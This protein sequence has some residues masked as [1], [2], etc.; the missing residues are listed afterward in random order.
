MND[1][2]R[3]KLRRSSVKRS[4]KSK[5]EESNIY[6][7]EDEE[8]VQPKKVKKPKKEK[9]KP[10]KETTAEY[11][12][13]ETSAPSRR[14][15]FKV[16]KG[17]KGSKFK[18]FLRILTALVIIAVIVFSFSYFL[19]GGI[20]E[21]VSGFFATLGSGE[22]PIEYD[23]SLIA[24]SQ[25]IGSCNYLLNDTSLC[26]YTGGGKELFKYQ[27]GFTNPV[28]SVSQTRAVLFNEG[29]D[30]A[31]IFNKSG[32]MKTIKPGSKIINATVGRNGAFAISCVGGEY[33]ST[34]YVYSKK[35]KKVYTW[36]SAKD[37]VNSLCLSPN[38]KKLAV[39]TLNV[40]NAEATDKL[41]VLEYNS[42]DP[43]FTKDFK[44]EIILSMRST[45]FGFSTVSERGYKYF[46]WRNY[47]AK[48]LAVKN[49]NLSLLRTNGGETLLVFNR[50]NDKTDNRIV[51]LSSLGNEKGAFDVNDTITDIQ[52][53]GGKIYIVSDT[54]IYVYNKKGKLLSSSKCEY[55]IK[56]FFIISSNRIAAIMD[57]KIEKINI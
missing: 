37:I 16:I 14:K 36:N 56:R 26:A 39:S 44:D 9:V 6:F 50:N 47:K 29:G 49:K 19:P 7:D 45:F 1:Y 24:D 28:L 52:F 41:L 12:N 23:G 35:A 48:E 32:L 10:S 13:D 27:H 46:S 2:K 25:A 21:T 42:A 33:T 20:I 51:L 15:N 55:G 5:S 57:D 3:K 4:N 53:K 22:Y 30:T 40:S 11:D 31:L 8:V 38:G 54:M 18:G 43:V 34:V 17:E